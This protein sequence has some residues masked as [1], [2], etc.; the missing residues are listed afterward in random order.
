MYTS[1]ETASLELDRRGERRVSKKGDEKDRDILHGDDCIACKEEQETKK[2][3]ENLEIVLLL[4]VWI[5]LN[6]EL[7]TGVRS[8]LTKYIL[9]SSLPIC[10]DIFRFFCVTKGSATS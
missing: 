10:R 5:D 3:P 4:L 9:N 2:L 8:H 1:L 6:T 7:S